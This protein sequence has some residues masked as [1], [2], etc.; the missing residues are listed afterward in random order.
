MEKKIKIANIILLFRFIPLSLFNSLRIIINKNL[1]SRV[2]T[3]I[4]RICKTREY[5]IFSRRKK[6]GREVVYP[7]IHPPR[8]ILHMFNMFG[9]IRNRSV[10]RLV[11]QGLCIVVE[12]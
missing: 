4:C 10:P 6:G 3:Y 11:E 12:D 7:R 5:N 9:I 8:S 1:L 2:Y